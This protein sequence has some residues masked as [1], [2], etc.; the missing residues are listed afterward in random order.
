MAVKVRLGWQR[1]CQRSRGHE[2]PT[3]SPN[4]WRLAA[5]CVAF[6]AGCFWHWTWRVYRCCSW[7]RLSGSVRTWCTTQLA[8]G[9]RI[10]YRRANL[11]P[12]G[13]TTCSDQTMQQTVARQQADSPS[14]VLASHGMQPALQG[15]RCL[16]AVQVVAG[17]HLDT[18]R[19][20]LVALG[21]K[22]EV[23]ASPILAPIS[24]RQAALVQQPPT[25]ITHPPTCMA[26]LGSSAVANPTSRLNMGTAPCR[27]NTSFTQSTMWSRAAICTHV[28]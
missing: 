9:C 8:K 6:S 14:E 11:T 15:S 18:S 27:Q 28:S 21:R 7:G 1:W 3:C 13:D 2:P 12:D 22:K 4:G 26:P 5:I 17:S 25:P 20:I 19:L 10:S 16:A 23:T 24:S